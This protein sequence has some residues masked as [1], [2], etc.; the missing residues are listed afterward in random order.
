MKKKSVKLWNSSE[1][2]RKPIVFNTSLILN[3]MI[4]GFAYLLVKQKFSPFSVNAIVLLTI[5]SSVLAL[6]TNSDRPEG[7]SNKEYVLGFIMTLAASALWGFILPLTE[8]TYQKA[9][10]IID[11][12]LVM[13]IQLYINFFA[14]LFGIVG[15]LINND[16]K[17]CVSVS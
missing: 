2:I 4:A 17:V 12:P 15:M 10:Q 8:F 5:G 3:P 7:E 14:T 11:F 1:R 16:F 13:E 9:K 6:H